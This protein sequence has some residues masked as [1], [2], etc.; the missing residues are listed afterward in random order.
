[1]GVPVAGDSVFNGTMDNAS[2]VSSLI[3]TARIPRG[4]TARSAACCS[5]SSPARRR[6]C[7][8]SY[9]W[10]RRPTVPLGQVA[11]N[12]NVDM[13][14]PIIPLTNMIVHGVDESTLGD[15]ARSEAQAAGHRDPSGPRAAAEP[16]H[17]QRP[18]QLHPRGRPGD[19]ALGGRRARARRRTPCS[20]RGPATATTSP[21]TTCPSPMD[22]GA[23]ADLIHFVARL[24]ERVANQPGRPGWKDSS[25][26]KR[27][28]A[29]P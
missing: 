9:Y 19:R 6:A 24:T 23:A 10:T 29:T 25:F 4:A 28:A 16:V 27:Y 3:E 5:S 12:V 26:F 7:S 13:V 22:P 8:G 17:P 20:R 21:R 11:A 2:G 1:V 15:L 14:L 18:V